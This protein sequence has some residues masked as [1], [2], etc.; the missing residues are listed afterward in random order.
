M[1]LEQLR[2]QALDFVDAVLGGKTVV[3][4]REKVE[5]VVNIFVSGKVMSQEVA[6]GVL[7]LDGINRFASG[8]NKVAS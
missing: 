3:K 4:P 5:E 8:K 6:H 7:S 1:S 2:V